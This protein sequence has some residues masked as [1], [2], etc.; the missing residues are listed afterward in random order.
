MN[1][2]QAEEHFSAHFEDTL[3]YQVLRD[4]EAHLSECE[5]CQHEYAC[6]QESVKAVQQLPQI[7]P[8]ADFMPSL[9]QR[10]AE[11]RREVGDVREIVANR[12]GTATRGVPSSQMGV[13]W[14]RCLNSYHCS[15]W[16]PLSRRFFVQSR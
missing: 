16:L 4:F 1:C 2:L 5:A 11:E 6:F 7:E 3:N 9:L 10:L 8:S 13:Q 14:T 12:L 15:W